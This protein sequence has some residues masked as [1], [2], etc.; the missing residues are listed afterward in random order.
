MPVHKLSQ[1]PIIKDTNIDIC[2]VQGIFIVMI[3]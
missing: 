3:R 2:P 1:V